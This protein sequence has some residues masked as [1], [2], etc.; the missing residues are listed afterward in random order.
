MSHIPRIDADDLDALETHS[1]SGA[2]GRSSKKPSMRRL[3]ATGES[4]HKRKSS[5]AD[6]GG[7]D[8]AKSD[9]G[10]VKSDRGK[11]SRSGR[12]TPV[13]DDDK[14][15]GKN[16][17]G[18]SLAGDIGRALLVTPAKAVFSAGAAAGHAVGHFASGLVS[19]MLK[20]YELRNYAAVSCL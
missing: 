14:R 1:D 12:D 19:P 20:K 9:T 17:K 11:P 10:S 3:G 16:A 13:S 5:R 2:M 8:D 6:D 18:S 15:K 4:G 7:S